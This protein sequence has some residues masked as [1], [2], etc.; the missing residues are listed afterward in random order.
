M[1]VLLLLLLSHKDTCYI[2]F[3]TADLEHSGTAQNQSTSMVWP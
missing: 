3:M 2:I 1:G